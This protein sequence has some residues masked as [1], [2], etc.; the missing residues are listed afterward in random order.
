MWCALAIHTANVGGHFHSLAFKEPQQRNENVTLRA[1][2]GHR[3]DLSWAS[4]HQAE[5]PMGCS[6]LC[7]AA[8]NLNE[9]LSGMRLPR[10]DWQQGSGIPATEN[11]AKLS[12]KHDLQCKV[13]DSY[14]CRACCCMKIT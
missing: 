13:A 5:V 11:P 10:A 7:P 1:P 12:T 9:N 14:Y 8:K 6:H 2:T 3:A 4:A